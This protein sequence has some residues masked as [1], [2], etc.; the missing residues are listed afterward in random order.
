MTDQ[1]QQINGISDDTMKKANLYQV[2]EELILS[3]HARF[4]IEDCGID[5]GAPSQVEDP[6]GIKL[7]K[8]RP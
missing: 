1:D 2:I 8:T 6:E 4:L 5:L 3:E 7:D